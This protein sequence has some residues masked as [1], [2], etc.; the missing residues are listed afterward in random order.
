MPHPKLI[1]LPDGPQGEERS[2]LG[3]GNAGQ[4]GDVQALVGAV[5]AQGLAMGATF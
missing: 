3:I 5:T 4:A 2:P 1:A